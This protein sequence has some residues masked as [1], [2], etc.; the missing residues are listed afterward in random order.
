MLLR[1]FY[2]ELICVRH[3][4]YDSDLGSCPYC[5]AEDRRTSKVSE[6]TPK[7]LA[8]FQLS[9]KFRFVHEPLNLKEAHDSPVP[10]VGRE[11]LIESLSSRLALSDGGSFLITGFRGVGKT[12]FVNQAISVLSKKLGSGSK[13]V[14]KF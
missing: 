10:F 4:P 14:G 8:K 12:S 6:K 7:S 13:T 9:P 1:R 11:T 5:Q 2:S 3:G